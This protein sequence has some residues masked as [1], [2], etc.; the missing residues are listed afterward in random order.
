MITRIW[1]WP[2]RRFTVFLFFTSCV[3]FLITAIHYRNISVK[4]AKHDS[5]YRKRIIEHMRPV[6]RGGK[7]AAKLKPADLMARGLQN[8]DLRRVPRLIH[9]SWMSTELPA[10]FQRWS[11]SCRGMHPEWEW[12]LWTD[13]DNANLVKTYF[14]WLEETYRALPSEIYRVDLSRSLYMYAFGG[15]YADL[16]MECL[17]PVESILDAYGMA[18]SP[19]TSSENA[20]VAF[21]GRMGLHNSLWA[22]IP[23]AWMLS[24]PGH[25]FFLLPIQWT[26]WRSVF[27]HDAFKWAPYFGT[28]ESVTGP[29]ALRNAILEYGKSYGPEVSG[30]AKRLANRLAAHPMGSMFMNQTARG[31]GEGH[32]VELL[33]H[34]VIYPL[35]WHSWDHVEEEHTTCKSTSDSLDVN[36]CKDMLEVEAKGSITITY[37]SHTHEAFDPSGHSNWSMDHLY[38]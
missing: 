24:T 35:S 36:L 18:Q 11:D 15:L 3:I 20:P 19:Q 28:A 14:P 10:R 33:H 17:H 37:W 13:E 32:R 1:A 27:T 5:F 6:P 26:Q 22:S 16:D 4:E 9:Q 2:R 34:D 31:E 8:T 21:F 25:P 12:V 29:I 7:L 38:R 30:G 23:N